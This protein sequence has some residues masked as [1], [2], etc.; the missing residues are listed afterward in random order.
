[1][2]DGSKNAFDE[3]DNKSDAHSLPRKSDANSI[4]VSLPTPCL[5]RHQLIYITYAKN[6]QATRLNED[7]MEIR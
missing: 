2:H 4:P 6:Q 7:S 3:K 1:M 5:Q